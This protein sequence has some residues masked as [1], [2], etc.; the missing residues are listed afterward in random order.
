MNSINFNVFMGLF[1]TQYNACL[2]MKK[3]F[4]YN[5]NKISTLKIIRQ[6]Y[7]FFIAMTIVTI[8][9]EKETSKS[10]SNLNQIFR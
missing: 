9:A 5:K 6:I 2:N 8:M 7:E 1:I 10:S 3:D 4:F